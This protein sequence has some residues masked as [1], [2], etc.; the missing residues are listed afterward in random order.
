VLDNGAYQRDVHPIMLGVGYDVVFGFEPCLWFG[1][2]RP[3]DR[4]RAK[5]FRHDECWLHA[6]FPRRASALYC[7]ASKIK[8]ANP[9]RKSSLR[10]SASVLASKGR[11]MSLISGVICSLPRTFSACARS[12][13]SET[14][15]GFSMLQPRK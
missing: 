5:H 9:S 12:R 14:E 3:A 2:L 11:R 10:R 7:C 1:R 6:A 13:I 4:N 15:G 8:L